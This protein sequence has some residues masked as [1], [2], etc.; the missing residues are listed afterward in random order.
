MLDGHAS[1]LKT[2]KAINTK[3]GASIIFKAMNKEEA[4]QL[5]ISNKMSQYIIV[6]EL[7]N[8]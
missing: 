8:K 6:S 1:Q 5:L 4:R 3:I 2:Y 7:T